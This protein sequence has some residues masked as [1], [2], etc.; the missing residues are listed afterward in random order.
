[1][2]SPEPPT[3]ADA[4][5]NE[6]KAQQLDTSGRN[7]TRQGRGRRYGNKRAGE[8]ARNAE[9]IGKEQRATGRN[10]ERE[11]K[12]R[13]DSAIYGRLVVMVISREE[14]MG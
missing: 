13:G 10:R 2:Q 12:R 5:K 11:R 1:M 3:S 14:R 9:E 6:V 4:Q 8:R 7:G